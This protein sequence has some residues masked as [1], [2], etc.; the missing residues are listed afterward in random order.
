MKR[1]LLFFVFLLLIIG[2]GA[3]WW[4]LRD[5]PEKVIRDA[6]LSLSKLRSV[7]EATLDVAWKNPQ[8]Q[9]TTGFTSLM[10]VDVADISMPLVMGVLRIGAQGM[11]DQDQILDFAA[12][13]QAVVFRPQQVSTDWLDRYSTLAG[14]TSTTPFLQISREAFLKITGYQNAIAQ[15]KDAEIRQLMPFVIPTIYATSDL[16]KIQM[17]DDRDGVALDIRFLRSGLQPVLIAASKAW[18]GNTPL[19]AS[20]YTWI[21]KITDN[22]L[23]GDFQIVLDA[24]TRE[25]VHIEGSWPDIEQSSAVAGEVRFRLDFAGLNEKVIISLPHDAVEVTAKIA[26]GL[27]PSVLTSTGLKEGYVA[28]TSTLN[29]SASSYPRDTDAYSRYYDTMKRK[30]LIQGAKKQKK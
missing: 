3:A 9:A 26:P 15:N 1:V 13:K 27:V 30:G 21:E 4:Y 18:K 29:N 8:T 17:A 25:L 10:Q 14:T 19:T 22:M 11:Q 20:D 23:A 28:P 16:R 6:V 12:D 7:P 2:G 5:T 24:K